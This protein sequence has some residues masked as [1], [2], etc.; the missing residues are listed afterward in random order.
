MALERFIQEQIHTVVKEWIGEGKMFTAFEVSLAVKER[1]VR[2][3]SKRRSRWSG[4]RVGSATAIA[5]PCLRRGFSRIAP[6]SA[7]RLATI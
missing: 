7:R 4:E 3:Q 6:T 1:G 5:Q 2:D